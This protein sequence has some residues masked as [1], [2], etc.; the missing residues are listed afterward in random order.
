MRKSPGDDDSAVA[1][2]K[3]QKRKWFWDLGWLDL[4]G[5]EASANP[6]PSREGRGKNVQPHSPLPL[7]SCWASLW[8]NPTR[9]QRAEESSHVT[10]ENSFLGQD[11]RWPVQQRET[12]LQITHSQIS[13]SMYSPPFELCDRLIIHIE[14]CFVLAAVMIGVQELYRQT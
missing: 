11:E 5:A 12:I 14:F 7:I 3:D 13:I 8:L 9:T 10:M 4:I 1:S 6:Q 2:C